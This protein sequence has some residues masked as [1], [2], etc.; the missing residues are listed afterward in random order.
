MLSKSRVY[1][2][3][4][5]MFYKLTWRVRRFIKSLD[6]IIEKENLSS[7]RTKESIIE[8]ELKTS[9]LLGVLESK[10]D[11]LK[12]NLSREINNT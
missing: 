11:K 4:E 1:L 3:L 9:V 12:N 5:T 8:E 2:Y 6:I 10:I 7:Q